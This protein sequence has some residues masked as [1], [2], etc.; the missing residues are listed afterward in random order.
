MR[1]SIMLKM[2]A[3][4]AIFRRGRH[5]GRHRCSPASRDETRFGRTN[6]LPGEPQTATVD[7]MRQVTA[8]Q[9]FYVVFPNVPALPGKLGT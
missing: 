2:G 6:I 7:P 9:D 3:I 8:P 4:G 5:E 1:Q